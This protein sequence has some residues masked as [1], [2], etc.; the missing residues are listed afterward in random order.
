[1]FGKRE[2]LPSP[3]G[4]GSFLFFLNQDS[5]GYEALEV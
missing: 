5:A 3:A 1:M 4:D 2:K